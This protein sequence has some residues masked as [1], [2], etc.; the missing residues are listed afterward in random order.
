MQNTQENIQIKYVINSQDKNLIDINDKIVVPASFIQRVLAAFVDVSI[1]LTLSYLIQIINLDKMPY[2]PLSL[3]RLW[4][5]YYFG[6]LISCSTTVGG[7][8]FRIY[9]IKNNGEKISI[10]KALIKGFFINIFLF[11]GIAIY[12]SF[13]TISNGVV[14]LPTLIIGGSIYL[15]ISSTTFF[16]KNKR[17][18]I[19][20]F[21]GTMVVST[22]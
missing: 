13:F 6:S 22:N 8:L 9:T 18:L 3:N 10:L 1:I 4:S 15:I 5:L 12:F 16:S 21:S 2:I 20:L 14:I 11:L 19:D 17:S 7:K